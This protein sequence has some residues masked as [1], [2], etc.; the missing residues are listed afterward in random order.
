MVVGPDG[1]LTHKKKSTKN[2]N[3]KLHRNITGDINESKA[4]DAINYK[5]TSV[6]KAEDSKGIKEK[7]IYTEKIQGDVTDKDKSV[8][9]EQNNQ[10]LRES[11]KTISGSVL[12]DDKRINEDTQNGQHKEVKHRVGRTHLIHVKEHQENRDYLQKAEM[13]TNSAKGDKSK[14]NGNNLDN[15]TYDLYDSYLE[16]ASDTDS[17]VEDEEILDVVLTSEQQQMVVNVLFDED[18]RLRPEFEK[19]E[20]ERIVVSIY[21]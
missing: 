5:V 6:E 4:R 17:G 11:G 10:E 16:K 1:V 19:D 14:S 9:Q 18:M 2:K 7:D 15:K 8:S 12:N 20:S 13:K 21:K 3:T